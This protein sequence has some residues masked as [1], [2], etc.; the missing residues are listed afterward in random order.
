MFVNVVK[1]LAGQNVDVFLHSRLGRRNVT[2]GGLDEFFA[3]DN[4][5][6]GDFNRHTGKQAPLHVVDIDVHS[7]CYRHDEGDPNYTNGAGDCG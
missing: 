2:G 4:C 3:F 5:D 6:S 7:V 1:E